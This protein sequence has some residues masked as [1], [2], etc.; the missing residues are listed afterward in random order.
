MKI[1]NLPTRMIPG[2][3]PSGLQTQLSSVQKSRIRLTLGPVDQTFFSHHHGMIVRVT[4]I[5]GG[6]LTGRAPPPGP[7]APARPSGARSAGAGAQYHLAATVRRPPNGG[8]RPGGC[9]RR[10]AGHSD[11]DRGP[12]GGPSCPGRQPV[13][14]VTA[15]ASLSDSES[16]GQHCPGRAGRSR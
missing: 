15:L 5:R 8:P 6:A 9:G 14:F 3:W 13:G 7:A 12:G 11:L 10:P 16:A 4:V 2:L 1:Q